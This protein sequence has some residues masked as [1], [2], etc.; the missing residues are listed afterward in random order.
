MGSQPPASHVHVGFQGLMTPGVLRKPI[1]DARRLTPPSLKHRVK[2]YNVRLEHGPGDL[3][4]SR[5]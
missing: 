1:L 2:T 5:E 3:F 4:R